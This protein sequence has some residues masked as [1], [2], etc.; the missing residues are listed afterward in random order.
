MSIAKFFCLLLILSPVAQSFAQDSEPEKAQPTPTATIDDI[1]WIAGAWSGEA[2][3]GKFEET[4]NAPSSGTMVGMFKFSKDEKVSF[5]E[6]LTISAKDE[7][8]VLRLK[9]F[10][11]DLKGWE[12]KDKAMEFPLASVSATQAK[13]KGLTFKKLNENQMQIIVAQDNGDL[14]FNCKRNAAQSASQSKN[15]KTK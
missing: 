11:A 3:G 4:W 12:E 14:I 8:L 2:M 15:S 6:L 1:Q 9:H 5:Y 10:G 13:F 7:S